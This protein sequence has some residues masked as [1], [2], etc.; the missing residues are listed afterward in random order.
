MLPPW[1]RKPITYSGSIRQV[2]KVVGDLELNTVCESA[3]CPNISECWHRKRITFMVLGNTCTRGC[4]FCGVPLGKPKKPDP[5]EPHRVLKAIEDLRLNY[6]V[7]T[8]VTRDDLDDG[9]AGY[10]AELIYKIRTR[11]PQCR[12]EVLV[13]D[14]NGCKKAIS[15]V[16]DAEPAVF[17]HNIETVPR[18]YNKV[19]PRA[20]YQRSLKV[21][22]IAKKSNPE[23]KT[24]SGMFLG[25]G[26]K[27]DEV[28]KVLEDLRIAGCDMITMGQ[29]LAPSRDSL[30]I[31]DFIHPS[32]FERLKETAF[33]LGFSYVA[34]GPFV[35]SSYCVK[36][37]HN[38]WSDSKRKLYA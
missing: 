13:P 5:T 18:L 6:V 21:L 33:D 28:I 7:I 3:L 29:Y 12:T 22:S 14:F 24:K 4:P 30:K 37:E 23:L 11:L 8:S 34:S 26:E 25:L 19:R 15:L 38:L 27:E 35:R 32:Q 16:V 9:G 20:E 31:N 1:L 17:G 36:R 10:F 2:K